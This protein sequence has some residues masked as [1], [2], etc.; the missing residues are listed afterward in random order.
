[1]LHVL[2]CPVTQGES[3]HNS[4]RFVSFKY[5]TFIQLGKQHYIYPILQMY[6]T[7]MGSISSLGIG[8][9][10]KKSFFSSPRI[11][12]CLPRPMMELSFLYLNGRGKVISTSDL[13]DKQVQKHNPSVASTGQLAKGYIQGLLQVN[14]N[15]SLPPMKHTVLLIGHQ[16]S[17]YESEHWEPKKSLQHQ[18]SFLRYVKLSTGKCS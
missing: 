11:P 1:M 13:Q 12:G 8:D 7:I 9:L 6:K 2:A 15:V 17:S 3:T 4:Q 16:Y 18:S 14:G 5:L 10:C